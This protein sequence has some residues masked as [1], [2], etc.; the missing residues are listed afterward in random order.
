MLAAATYAQQRLG[1]T[2]VNQAGEPLQSDAL[3]K[4][5]ANATE[6]LTKAGFLPGHIATLRLF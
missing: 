6:R 3:R 1:G 5:V 2:L 4:Q